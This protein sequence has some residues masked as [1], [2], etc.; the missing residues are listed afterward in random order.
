MHKKQ[1]SY[2]IK[3]SDWLRYSLI[4]TLLIGIFFRFVNL[5]RK[6]YWGDETNTSLRIA[7]YTWT[8]QKQQMYNAASINPEYL[9]KYQHIN[10]EKG[11]IN[12]VKGLATE[13]PQNTPLYFMMVRFW[14][15]LFGSSVTAVRSFS[16]VM[17]LLAFPC[18]YWLCQEL[19]RS[20]L[21]GWVAIG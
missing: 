17:S 14:V 15:Q 3:H 13:E 16:A 20:S 4:I 6:V 1:K 2:R 7:G 18:I 19:F 8:E 5:D 10:P 9:Q 11:L 21:T 12:T